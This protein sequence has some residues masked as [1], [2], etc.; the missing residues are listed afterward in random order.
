[1]AENGQTSFRQRSSIAGRLRVLTFT[2]SIFFLIE[3]LALFITTQ[4][5][6]KGLSSLHQDIQINT[7]LR[8][9]REAATLL[10][11]TFERLQREESTSDL[12]PIIAGSLSQ[13]E[14]ILEEATEFAKKHPTF[15]TE[16]DP[17]Q[18]IFNSIKDI[19]AKP[20]ASIS[21][22]ERLIITQYLI[23]M[24]DSISK[25]QILVSKDA[26]RLFNE[27][28]RTRY[29]PIMIGVA[30]ALIFL[31]A[32]LILGFRAS[33]K[34]DNSVQKLIGRT[35]QLAKGDFDLPRLDIEA[36]EIGYLAHA[37]EQMT[38]ELKETT[39]SR[40]YVLNILESM[41]T[42]VV[43]LDRS[44]LI[45]RANHVTFDTF[46]YA[47]EKLVG[48]P[49]KLLFATPIRIAPVRDLECLCRTATGQTIPTSVS[50]SELRDQ[51]LQLMGFVCVIV[52]VT[53]RKKNED[54]LKRR[55]IAL[56]NSNRELEAFSYSVSHD[57]RAPL[58]AIDGFSHAL[59]ED[60]GSQLDPEATKHLERIRNASQ[61]MGHLIDDML[62][63]SRLS[64]TEMKLER[65]S[66]SEAAKAV[67]AELRESSPERKVEVDIADNMFAV[68][69]P[70]LLQILLKN[71]IGNAWKYTSKK[72]VAKIEVGQMSDEGKINFFVR[73]NGAG[74]NMEYATNLFGAFQ[75]LH[76]VR[77]FPGTGI[78]LATVMRIMRRHGGD[79]WA[80]AE[81]DKGATFY[82][83]F[84]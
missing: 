51:H 61:S 29:R 68:A 37:F 49:L 31:I 30:L 48:E 3:F 72:E 10:R 4:M 9:T 2:V 32:I 6:F 52:D 27:V 54:E 77:E 12:A 70:A 50:I 7:R 84:P 58:R 19:A 44:G 80:E 59:V 21:P 79:V 83:H 35:K 14:S 53:E 69:D 81:V 74:F 15:S 55:S 36:D 5:F 28:E 66:V 67:V 25:L 45:Q 34:I 33:R 43:V 65:V 64:R 18:N 22:S 1:V 46:G 73:D 26:D 57:L 11:D 23:E 16:L 42:S 82:F 17:I 56:I 39:V 40:N 8:Q 78:G 20:I 75:R 76:S 38:G 47:D 24:L 63:L 41:V 60:F 13:T 71:L 62:K